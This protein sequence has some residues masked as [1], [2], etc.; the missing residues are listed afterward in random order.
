MN[1]REVADV[2]AVISAV[3]LVLGVV[4]GMVG[5]IAR[6]PCIGLFGVTVFVAG[7][8]AAVVLGVA[9]LIARKGKR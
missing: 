1:A 3:C 5:Y 4:A 9:A 7:L 8:L 2:A 6:D